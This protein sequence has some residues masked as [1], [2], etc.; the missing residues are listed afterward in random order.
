M[1]S[2][3]FARIEMQNNP[4]VFSF[5]ITCQVFVRCLIQLRIG[6]LAVECDSGVY[7]SQALLDWPDT[8]L[9]KGQ[10]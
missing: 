10:S 2:K 8:G 5:G 6:T 7:L 1:I 9:G 4:Q 3:S